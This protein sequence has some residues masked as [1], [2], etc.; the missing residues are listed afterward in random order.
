M[1][2]VEFNRGAIKPVECLKQGWAL[3]KDQYWLFLGIVVVAILIGGAIP[4]GILYGPM[5]CGIY[6]CFFN[7][8]SGRPVSFDQLFK[9]FDYF[10]Q[11]AIAI[12]IQVLPMMA[13]MI[14]AYVPLILMPIFMVPSGG[15]NSEPDPAVF[16][17]VFGAFSLFLFGAIVVG[18]LIGSLF[19]F[20]IPLI[21]ERNLTAIEALKTSAKA[22][23]GNLGGL[24]G[25]YLLNVLIGLVGILACYFG[26]FFLMPIAFA[27]YAVAYRQVFPVW[28]NQMN[29]PPPP[30][31][32]WQ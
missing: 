4:F 29:Y 21:V 8:M 30:P 24:I 13:L 16:F 10:L 15:R 17:T 12:V 22:V 9:G 26:I 14:L 25:L 20:T 23:I 32:N 19:I 5:L 2:N 3:I 18:G 7:K 28:D 6:V 31:Q 11:S 27:S 1:N